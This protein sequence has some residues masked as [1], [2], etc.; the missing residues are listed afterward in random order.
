MQNLG[1]TQPDLLSCAEGRRIK[2]G[3]G[4][5]E[6]GTLIRGREGLKVSLALPEAQRSWVIQ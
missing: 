5:G 4:G 2:T 6:A 3:T 1:K